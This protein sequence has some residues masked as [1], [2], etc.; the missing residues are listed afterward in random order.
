MREAID[1]P[2]YRKRYGRRIPI[3]E[4]V[5]ADIR[6]CKGMCRFMVRGREKVKIQWKIYCIVHNRGKCGMVVRKKLAG[7]GE[8]GKGN[9]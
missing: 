3:I 4:A 1:Q 6:Y 2:G 8:K 9:R 5:F 7:Q